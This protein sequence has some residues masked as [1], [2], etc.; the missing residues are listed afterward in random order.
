M[1]SFNPEWIDFLAAPIA[2]QEMI[3]AIWLIVKGFN[4][5]VAEL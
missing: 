1:Y 4:T 5:S 3:L 2:F